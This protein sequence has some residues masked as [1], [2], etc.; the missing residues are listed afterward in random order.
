MLK[1]NGNNLVLIP[2]I[3]IILIISFVMLFSFGNNETGVEEYAAL[4]VSTIN[5]FESLTKVNEISYEMFDYEHYDHSYADT[6]KLHDGYVFVESELIPYTENIV[7]IIRRVDMTGMEIWK[8]EFD[9]TD[10]GW[11]ND[12]ILLNNRI[13]FVND[14]YGL[15][16]LDVDTGNVL[17]EDYSCSFFDISFYNDSILLM[18]SSSV[19][20]VDTDI[21]ILYGYSVS[22]LNNDDFSHRIRSIYSDSDGIYLLLEKKNKTTSDISSLIVTLNS[23]LTFSS[24]IDITTENQ[25]SYLYLNGYYRTYINFFKNGDYFYQIGKDVHKIDS[26]GNDILIVDYNQ[27]VDGVYTRVYDAIAFDDFYLTLDYQRTYEELGWESDFVYLSVR[28]SDFEIISKY[29]ISDSFHQYDSCPQ[30]LTYKDGKI[31]VK[32]HEWTTYEYYI[33]EF[34]FTAV[35]DKCEILSGTGYDIGDEVKCGSEEFYV[36]ENNG[37]DV[38]LMGKYNLMAGGTFEKVMIEELRVPSSNSL[39][40]I[41]YVYSHPDIKSK[42]EVGYEVNRILETFDEETSE[43]VYSGA[44]LYDEYEKKEVVI[45][46]DK[47]V[48]SKD[49]LLILAAQ[50]DAF[51]PNLYYTFISK[52]SNSAD[53]Y[54]AIH[55][56][57]TSGYSNDYIMLDEPVATF[58]ELFVNET[59]QEKLKGGYDF[60]DITLS[61]GTYLGLELTY[62]N[63]YKYYVLDQPVGTLEELLQDQVVVDYLNKGFVFE[64]FENENGNY[65]AIRFEFIDD[66]LSYVVVDGDYTNEKQLVNSTFM[67]NYFDQN[68]A[69]Y[70]THI[71]SGRCAIVYL[72][73]SEQIEYVTYLFSDVNSTYLDLL[74][75]E[76]VQ[77]YLSQGYA[78]S[79]EFYSSSYTCSTGNAFCSRTYYGL[80]FMK[81]SNYQYVNVLFDG[82]LGSSS[83]INNNE[84]VVS[85]VNQGYSILYNYEGYYREQIGTN[86]YSSYTTNAGVV[87]AKYIGL[88]MEPSNKDDFYVVEKI[89][90]SVIRQDITA[91]GAHGTIEGTPEPI[92]IGVVGANYMPRLYG[93]PVSNIY[94]TGFV[95]YNYY[96]YDSDYSYDMNKILYSYYDTLKNDGYQ[97]FDV[98]TITVSELNDIVYNVT[99]SDIPL[100]EW[101]NNVNMEMLNNSE[102][103]DASFYILGSIKDLMPE[104]YDWLWGTTYWTRTRDTLYD[105]FYA[106]IYFVDTLGFLCS[107]ESCGAAVGAGIR[108][109]VTMSISNFDFNVTTEANEGGVLTASHSSASSGEIITYEVTVNDGYVIKNFSVTDEFGNIIEVNG[110]KFSMPAADVLIKVEFA[111]KEYFIPRIEFVDGDHTNHNIG[112][113]YYFEARVY[114]DYDFTITDVLVEHTGDSVYSTDGFNVIDSKTLKADEILPGEYKSFVL[115]VDVHDFGTDQVVA[116][117]ISASGPIPYFMNIEAVPILD[118]KEGYT[119]TG[120]NI[121]NVLESG[122]GTDEYHQY[123]VT[124]FESSSKTFQVSLLLKDGECSKIVVPSYLTYE[125][126]QLEKQNYKLNKVEGVVTKNA[127]DFIVEPGSYDL[128]FFNIYENKGYFKSSDRAENSLLYRGK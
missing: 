71:N 78:V 58:E 119:T 82:P 45:Y 127:W 84:Q 117:V 26:N 98:N 106:W 99:G 36:I 103:T 114:N 111:K 115:A 79:K 12:M 41:A 44:V 100:E 76:D 101:Y 81:N 125:V 108:P 118:S 28:N 87:M 61:D 94:S 40:G 34:E 21:Q 68:Y 107:T 116:E 75:R 35:G 97:I 60:Y 14:Y 29:Q 55:F 42:L 77:D 57:G 72:L 121:C 56:Y 39:D 62:P 63:S 66:D 122:N 49:D 128:T 74:N 5:E 43:Y 16:V 120:L 51:N 69:Y 70:G 15:I 4:N 33:S 48:C 104:G 102:M 126:R 109:I 96:D 53:G 31:V 95:D 50:N 18:G 23:D 24:S 11:K 3:S 22:S 9:S 89:N 54:L 64:T 52:S 30:K 6:I 113:A 19:F 46:C 2:V 8:Y 80:T 20:I 37:I 67:K 25:D 27:E 110:N 38:K 13:Y 1:R 93:Y 91:I 17:F 83:D 88:G 105:E 73:K 47:E 86:S 10:A 112:D 32:W 92:E 7:T 59:I 85:L 90:P 124:G 123:I 65:Y